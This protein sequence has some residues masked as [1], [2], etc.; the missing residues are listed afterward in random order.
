MQ[1]SLFEIG[2]WKYQG[3]FHSKIGTINNRSHRDLVDTEEI[4]KRWKERMEE[5][6]TKDLNE[7]DYYNGVV[8]HPEPDLLE[9]K[10]K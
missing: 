9:C 5:L 4:K 7:P 10:V 6:Y 2:N 8:I 3:I 1:G